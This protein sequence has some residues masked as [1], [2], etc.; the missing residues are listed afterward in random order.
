MTLTRVQ[1]LG[2]ALIPVG[3]GLIAGVGL[4]GGANDVW[5]GQLL[6]VFAAFLWGVYTVAMRK[7]GVRALDAVAIVA[8]VSAF[9]YL[10]LYPFVLGSAIPAA[11]IAEIAFQAV[12]QGLI[13]GIGLYYAFNRAVVLLGGASSSLFIA[14]IPVL[15]ALFAI[16][17]LGEIPSGYD[18]AGIALITAGIYWGSG[19]R[20]PGKG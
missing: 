19:A 12:M 18:I 10:P 20:L 4:T 2:M 6:F 5:V 16:P 11:P 17:V 13:A 15:T 7:Q 14:A 1:V 9:F 3:G 8:G